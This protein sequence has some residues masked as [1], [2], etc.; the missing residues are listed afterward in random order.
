MGFWDD[1][2]KGFKTGFGGTL[3]VLGH[4]V[5]GVGGQISSMGKE[6]RKLHKGGKVPRT[7][8]FRLRVGEV[9]LNK[10]QQGQLRRAKTAKGKQAIINR[11]QKQRP[12]TMKGQKKKRRK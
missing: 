3:Q 1:F 4:A 6:I 12:K 9:V 7:G 11:V 2:G 5:P 10:T 8:N